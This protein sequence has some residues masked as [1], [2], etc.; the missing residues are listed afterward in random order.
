MRFL[1]WSIAFALLI[2]STYVAVDYACCYMRCRRLVSRLHDVLVRMTA[3]LSTPGVY[4]GVFEQTCI[5]PVGGGLYIE[6]ASAGQAVSIPAAALAGLVCT[7][8]VRD[9]SGRTVLQHRQVANV[10]RVPDMPMPEGSYTLE[11]DVKSG[12]PGLASIPYE[13]V[14]RNDIS[15]VPMI[16]TSLQMVAVVSS[17]ISVGI[18]AGM[19]V[20]R[21][22]RR[23]RLVA[24]GKCV[25]CEYDLTGN[26]S[27]ACPECG[28]ACDVADALVPERKFVHRSERD[29][30]D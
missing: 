15:L 28:T 13:V 24:T 30:E 23:R 11:I 27:G 17:I 29:Q 6:P 3:D 18:G 10:L 5:P 4:S 21:G 12:A 9:S 16:A 19:L 20:M 14:G 26:V 2:A 7:I 8:S 25:R 22:R 1:K